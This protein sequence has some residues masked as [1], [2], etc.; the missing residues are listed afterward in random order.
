MTARSSYE[1]NKLELA[2]RCKGSKPIAIRLG[3]TAGEVVDST[4]TNA[5]R[6]AWPTLHVSA[7]VLDDAK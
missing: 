4:A 6:L 1:G 5:N 7:T 3:R 2:F